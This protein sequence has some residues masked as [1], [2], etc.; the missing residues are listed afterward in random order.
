MPRP[1]WIY[2]L[3]GALS[4]PAVRFLFRLRARGL[5]NLPPGG[6]VLAA[7]HLSNF[8]PWAL[9]LP[10]FPRRYLR[11]MGKSELFW[12]PL[13]QIITAGGAFPVHR[14][15]GDLEAIET[16]KRLVR[17]GH[18]V[19]MF[20]EGTRQKKGLRKRY[21]PRPHTGAARIAIGAGC[22]LVPAAISGTDRLSRLGPLRVA[23]GEPLDLSD[24]DGH[25]PRDAAQQATDRL[26]AEIDRLKATL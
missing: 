19:V 8:D 13:K 6:Y 26:M 21:R 11:F 12:T 5:E 22:P 10:L 18:V 25:D 20:P 9:G 1:S 4:W 7:N 23:F 2:L 14:G 24:L 17:D 16:A 3:V 15:Q